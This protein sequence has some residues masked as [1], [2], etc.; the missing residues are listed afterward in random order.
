ME[1][2]K[3]VFAAIRV[4]PVDYQSAVVLEQAVEA[5]AH[6]AADIDFVDGKQWVVILLQTDGA[7]HPV[8]VA[9]DFD[10]TEAA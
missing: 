6:V 7:V 5:I 1:L 3:T 8:I 2:Q 9:E 4:L 10:G